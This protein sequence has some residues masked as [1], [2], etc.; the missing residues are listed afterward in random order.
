MRSLVVGGVAPGSCPGVGGAHRCGRRM[1]GSGVDPDAGVLED[2]QALVWAGWSGRDAGDHQR[3]SLATTRVMLMTY[4]HDEYVFEA[5]GA[6]ASGF[7][8]KDV[9]AEALRDV[10][11]FVASGHAF[12]CAIGDP[13]SRRRVRLTALCHATRSTRTVASSVPNRRMTLMCWGVKRWRR[14]SMS[15]LST[16]RAAPRCQRRPMWIR[17]LGSALRLRT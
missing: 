9:T 16:R 2:D 17:T 6:G 7:L 11:R 1:E 13:E 8:N 10:M 15:S 3:Q 14:A 12:A 5:L 4:E